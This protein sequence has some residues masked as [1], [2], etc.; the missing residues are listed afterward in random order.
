MLGYGTCVKWLIQEF[1]G[2]VPVGLVQDTSR[3]NSVIS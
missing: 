3:H 2:V 1:A